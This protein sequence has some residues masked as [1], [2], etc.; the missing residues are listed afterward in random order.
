MVE[1]AEKV[2]DRNIKLHNIYMYKTGVFEDMTSE[3]I[4]KRF[5]NIPRETIIQ[6]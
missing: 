2:N 6:D 3:E 1:L 5:P 4:S